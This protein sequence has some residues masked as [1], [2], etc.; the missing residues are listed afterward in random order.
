MPQPNLAGKSQPRSSIESAPRDRP[1]GLR[2][3]AEPWIRFWFAPVDPIGMHAVRALVGLL[4]LAWL[5]S[6]HAEYEALFGLSGWFDAQAY[7]EA[8]DPLVLPDG[9]PVPLGWSAWFLAQSPQAISAMYYGTVALAAMFTV[10]F[11]TRVTGILTWLSITSM[12]ENPALRYGGDVFLIVFWFSLALGYAFYRW[13]DPSESVIWRVL[14][15]RSAWLWVGRHD[16][17]QGTGSTAAGLAVRLLQ[18]HMA[19]IMTTSGLHKLQVSEWWS[20]TALWLPRPNFDLSL[21]AALQTPVSPRLWLVILSLSAYAVVAWQISFPFLMWRP[22]A[23]SL[24]IVAAVAGC[25]AHAAVFR[26]PIFGPAVVIGSLAFLESAQ[27]R[28]GLEIMRRW[29]VIAQLTTRGARRPAEPS[30]ET[31]PKN[32]T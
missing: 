27:W 26:L 13:N 7:R 32:L 28:R 6:F 20:G 10:G 17:G 15:S 5:L 25:I 4:T 8:Q 23:R 9:S 12:T 29:P 3:A 2:A 11:A 21:D 22:R 24:M 14:G 19:I 1:T 31:I 16:A 30:L 18:V